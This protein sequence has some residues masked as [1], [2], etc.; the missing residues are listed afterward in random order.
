MCV[1]TFQDSN[2][3]FANNNEKNCTHRT[4]LFQ[5]WR[6]LAS[7]FGQLAKKLFSVMATFQIL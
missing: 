3:R 1:C 7:K 6:Q 2:I 4:K 5:L